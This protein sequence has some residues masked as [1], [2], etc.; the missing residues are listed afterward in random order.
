MRATE[1][2]D[3]KKESFG[4]NRRMAIRTYNDKGAQRESQLNL[5]GKKP[6]SQIEP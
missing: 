6:K 1:N 4:R 5:C 2:N 3:R